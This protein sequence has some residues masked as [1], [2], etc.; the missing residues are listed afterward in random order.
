MREGS[1]SACWRRWRLTTYQT[2]CLRFATRSVK[3]YK[4]KSLKVTHYLAASQQIYMLAAGWQFGYL[5]ESLLGGVLAKWEFWIILIQMV[6]WKYKG[7]VPVYNN[8]WQP[9]KTTFRNTNFYFFYD[10][11]ILWSSI[12][13]INIV[14]V[15][16]A[17][18]GPGTLWTG[19]FWL[20][21]YSFRHSKV[22]S[23]KISH[24]NK[25]WGNLHMFLDISELRIEN[26]QK[27]LTQIVMIIWSQIF[28]KMP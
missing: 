12:F 25:T 3:L 13:K 26:K 17:P 5:I 8:W 24:K 6:G 15:L 16:S 2:T 21:Q 18:G 23:D 9:M 27:S 20:N 10:N 7:P 19:D 11:E 22:C 28:G 1:P 4:L 14:S